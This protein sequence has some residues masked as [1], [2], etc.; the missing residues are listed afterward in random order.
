MKCYTIHITVECIPPSKR[1]LNPSQRKYTTFPGCCKNHK[2]DVIWPPTR[3]PALH[4]YAYMYTHVKIGTRHMLFCV[5]FNKS[6]P[7]GW[8]MLFLRLYV[9]NWN[10]FLFLRLLP[11]L[12]YCPPFKNSVRTTAAFLELLF[13]CHNRFLRCFY[14]SSFY[15]FWCSALD[16][17]VSE[18]IDTYSYMH[19]KL[20]VF[21]HGACMSVYCLSENKNSQMLVEG[22]RWMSAFHL[23]EFFTFYGN[24]F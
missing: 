5:P 10:F 11:F 19:D 14:H 9:E 16:R 15:R 2:K 20:N 12:S 6:T 22:R 8:L 21:I 23:Q 24:C 3:N 7:Q 13:A 4:G 17:Q 1:N 18:D